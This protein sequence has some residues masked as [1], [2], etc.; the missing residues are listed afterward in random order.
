MITFFANLPLCLVGMEACGSSEYRARTIESMG[1]TVR[2]I[3]PVYVKAYLLGAKNDTNDAAAIRE[4]VQRPSMRFVPHKSREQ[5]DIQAV[6]RV[7]PPA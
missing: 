2:R 1:H 6:H 5:T 7:T 3:H 4:A